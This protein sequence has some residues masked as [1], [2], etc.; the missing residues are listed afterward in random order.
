MMPMAALIPDCCNE[1]L[2]SDLFFCYMMKHHAGDG[3]QLRS[4]EPD[5]EWWMDNA[6]VKLLKKIM[7]SLAEQSFASI[8][9]YE[10][11]DCSD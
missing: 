10:D 8:V 2:K 11:L 7:L 4:S 9:I 1:E 5:F 6:D 3:R